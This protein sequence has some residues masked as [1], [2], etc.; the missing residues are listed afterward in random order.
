MLQSVLETSPRSV[1]DQSRCFLD[2]RN[3]FVVVLKAYMDESGTHAGSPVVTVA[4]YFARPRVWQGWTKEWNRAKRPIKVVHA[5]DCNN[6]T[7]EFAGWDRERR[8]A[9]VAELLPVIPRHRI[10]GVAVGIHMDAFHREMQSRPDLRKLFGTPYT[11]CFQWTVQTVM[12][13]VGDWDARMSVSFIHEVNDYHSEANEAFR[14][15]RDRY[16][17]RAR[18]LS[19]TDKGDYVPLQAADVLAYEANHFLRDP[20]RKKRRSWLALDPDDEM[21]RLRVRHYGEANM[22]DFV[23]RLSVLAGAN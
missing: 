14:F 4:A 11:A 12:D 3:G 10:M 19:F 5:S 21:P 23:R 8:D 1:Y 15:I 16:G 6:L 17:D 20:E 2:E 9:W 22:S 7:G 18:G 13:M